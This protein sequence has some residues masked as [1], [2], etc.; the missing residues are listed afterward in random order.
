M[1]PS[2]VSDGT[3]LSR[4]EKSPS[5]KHASVA[6]SEISADDSLANSAT[7]SDTLHE[8]E[9]DHT[10]PKGWTSL[11]ELD[12]WK[13][14]V[15]NIPERCDLSGLS[16]EPVRY[17]LASTGLDGHAL[18][19]ATQSV[20]ILA[21]LET[22]LQDAATTQSL[23][24]DSLILFAV[25]QMLKGFGNGSHT[26]TATLVPQTK[27]APA[28]ASSWRTSA[29]IVD[30]NDR[31]S[32]SV[33]KAMAEIASIQTSPK[34]EDED[35][36]PIILHDLVR[37][38]LVD[39]FVVLGGSLDENILPAFPLVLHIGQDQTP[40]TLTICYTADLFDTMVIQSFLSA[41]CTLLWATSQPDKLVS[42]IEL[43]PTE[44]VDQM[45]QWNDTDGDWPTE[46]RL[47]HLFEESTQR[48]P[49]QIAII[50]GDKRVTYQELNELANLL[51]RHICSMGIKPEQLIGLFLDK[52]EKMI[53]AIL[54]VWKSGAAHVPID[55][56]YPNER[57]QFVLDDTKVQVLFASERHVQRLQEDVTGDREIQIIALEP[58]L[59]TL[60]SARS[61]T[62][63][64][65]QNLT[66]LPL[67][68][69]QLAYVTY[70]SGTTG[71]P[72]GIFKEHTSVVNSITD[73]SSKYGVADGEDEVILLFSAYV[74]EPFV[75]QM[76]MALT[77]GH[78][79]AIIRDEDKFDP[80]TLLPFIQTHKVT[81]LNG[82]ASVLQE[83]DFTTCPSLRRIILVGE[84]LTEARYMALRR[85]F[86]ARLFNEYGFTESAFVTALNIFEPNSSRKDMS[87]GRPVRN[88]K[89]YILD[90]NL[91][92]V[93]LGV[94]GELHIGGLGISR[95]Y[96]NRAELTRQKFLA[97][98]FQTDR[99]RERGLN[100][101]MYKTGDLAR[102]LPNGQVEYLGRADFQIKLRGIRIEPGEI[103]ATLA[104]YPGV[105]TSIVVSK[106]LLSQGQETN[107]DHLVAYFVCDEE[108][109]SEL[110]LLAFLETKLP[111]YMIPTRL[112]Q[113]TQIPV[114]INGKADL[115]ALP[116]VEVAVPRTSSKPTASQE[117]R[118]D[119]DENLATI[120]S[121]VLNVPREQIGLEQNFFRLG[122]HSITCI[123]LIARVRHVLGRGIN[124]EEV[125][126]TKT[127]RAMGDF[128]RSKEAVLSD[129]TS[130]DALCHASSAQ[131]DQTY[132][133]NS[134]QQG[135]VYHSLKTQQSDAYI[136][137][138]YLSY[139]VSLNAQLYKA[140]WEAV[141]KRH[142]ALRLR[143]SWEDQVSQ[144]VDSDA[145]LDWRVLDWTSVQDEAEQRRLLE[146]TQRADRTDAYSLDKGPLFRLYF[147]DLPGSRHW[148]IFSCHHSILDGWSLPLL[149][150]Y[151]HEAYLALVAGTPLTEDED[152]VYLQ[153]QKY[154]QEHRDDHLA[155][156]EEQIGRIDER[157]DMNALLNE[158]S[159][160]K[161]PLADYDQIQ[162][163]KTQTISLPWDDSV[164][165]LREECSA[166]GI[167]LHSILQL[168]WHLV[169]RAYGN[170][171]HT[172]T[173]TTIS[174]RNLPVGGVE[175]ALGLFIN[176]LPLIIDHDLCKDK[177]VL[178]AIA[179]VQNQVN[180]MNSRGHVELG[181]VSKDDLKHGLFDTL[182]VLENYPNLDTSKRALHQES[183]R[184]KIEGGTEKLS[185]PLAVIA[186][187]EGDSAC[188]FTIC[189][190]SE[191]FTD[192][193]IQDL[194]ETV[195]DA[196]HKVSQ[197]LDHPVREVEYLSSGQVMQ[198]DRWN[199][200]EAEFPNGTLHALFES[201][202][203]QKPDKIAVVYEDTSLTYRE[204]N[205][206]ANAMAYHLLSKV[207]IKPNQLIAL[208]IEKSEHLI[209]SILAVWKTG[210]AYVPIDAG[211]PDDRIKYILEDTRA[212]AVI[213][214]EKYI[215]R[216]R[217]LTEKPIPLIKSHMA[218]ELPR[219]H[220]HPLS[221][222]SPSDLAYTMYTSG[223]TGRP[224]GVM[225]E[226]HGVVNLAASLAQIFGLRETDDEV[227]LSFSN[228]VFDHFVEQMTDALLNGQTLVI[229]NDEM[230]GD[231][232]RLYRYIEK[233]KVTYLSGTPSVIS[234][235]EF[236]RFHS[237]L[238]RVDCVGEAFSEPVFDKIRETWPGL[239]INGYGPTEV[240]ITTHKR[241][242]PY[243]ERRTDKSIG[244]QV[245]NST[246]YVL[247]DDMKRVPI[248]AVGELYLGGDGV[249]RG[250]HNRPDLTA[251]RFPVNPF[252]SVQ[253]KRESRNGRLY[254][255]GDLVRWIQTDNGGEIEY[256]GRNDFQV[257]I[258]GQRI[259][260]GEIEAILSSF[261][262]IT[263][264]VILAKDRASDGQKYLV[265]YYVSPAAPTPQA[266][267][268]FM[269]ARL[270]DYMVP[271]RLMCID[272]FPVTVSGK[273]DSRALPIPDETVDGDIV[274]PRTEVERI[275]A[276]MWAELLDMSVDAI[277]IYSDFFSL[278]GDS[279]KSTRLSFAATQK[280]GVAVSV[281]SLFRHPTIESLAH[282][283]TRGSANLEEIVPLNVSEI[284]EIPVS[285]AQERLLYIYE[286]EGSGDAYNIPMH[287]E[288]EKGICLSSFE[289]AVRAMIGRHE[290]LRSLLVRS[291]QTS[292]HYQNIL[293]VDA[294]Q[295]L[296]T[297]E[298]VDCDSREAL[299][300][301]MS[302]FSQYSF[303]LTSE[304]PFCV[305]AYQLNG[306]SLHVS[307]VFHH[308]M[309]DAWSWDVFQRDLE[310]LYHAILS[311]GT[312]SLP[313]LRV[314]YKE[315]AAEHRKTLAS[316]QKHKVLVD[317]WS[318]KLADMEPLF[319]PTDRA[320][321]AQF[322]YAGNDVQLA[323]D[324][325]MTQNLREVAKREGSS[326]YTIM[327]TA[328]AFLLKVYT[329]QQDISIGIPV[330]HRT[331]PEFES[332][333]GFFINLLPLRVSVS[334]GS[335]HSLVKAV[336]KELV[337][338]Q[339]HQDMPFQEITK[340]LHVDHDPSR[341]PLVQTVFNWE[342]ES[343]SKKDAADRKPI[344]KEYSASGKAP[345][346]AKFDLNATIKE[347]AGQLM[348]NFN[349]ATSLF[350]E[351]TICGFLETYKYLLDQIVNNA[352]DSELS[353]HQATDSI[354]FETKKDSTAH[355]SQETLSAIFEHQV[356]LSANQI[357]ISDGS[358]RI[359]YSAL[360]EQANQLARWIMAT[361]EISSEDRIALMFDKSIEM[362]VSI[363]A[364]WK[365]GAAYVPLDPTYPPQRVNFILEDSNAKMIL[366]WKKHL[367]GFNHPSSTQVVALDTPE[368]ME[369]MQ[370]QSFENLDL[371]LSPSS[372]A[373]VI[374]TSGTTGKPKG[375][376]VEHRSVANLRNALVERYFGSTSGTHAVLLVSN[377]VF[378]FSLEQF[379]LSILSGNKLV[380]PPE[381]G[382][383]HECFYQIASQEK[384]TYISG[385]PSVLQQID[386]TRLAD[387]RMLTAAGEE[388]HRS[389]YTSMREQFKGPINNAYGITETT[390]YNL[391]TTFEGNA[392]FSKSLCE[393][394]PGSQ[395][396]VL[397]DQ[398]QRVPIN[399]VGELYL[400]GD[401][402][403]RGYLHQEAL[404]KDRF[405]PNP[406]S[407][408]EKMYKT[409]DLVRLRGPNQL[410][411]LGRRDQQVKL[412]GFRIE[413]AEVRDA[414]ASVPGVKESAVI[415]RY[416]GSSSSRTVSAL[417]GYYTLDDGV[418][419]TPVDIRERLG[420]FLPWFMIPSQFH[421][422][423]G[424]LPTTVNGKLDVARLAAIK[425]QQ[426]SESYSSPRNLLEVKLCQLWSSLLGLDACGIDDDLFALGGD[427]ISSLQLV[428]DIYRQL[429]RKV[430]VKDLF[431]HRTVRTLHDIV[432][433][434]DQKH[435]LLPPLRAEQGVVK[436]SAPLLP[437]QNWFLSK[438]LQQRDFW[439][440]CFSI[441]TPRLDVNQLKEAIEQL[442]D[443]H[444]IFRM[445]LRK[446]DGKFVQAFVENAT[447]SQLTELDVSKFADF[448]S[449]EKTLSSMQS[450]FNLE[451]G[452]LMAVSYLSGFKDGSARIW[453]A[454][455]HM[456]VD[457]VSWNI[458]L[459]DLETLY[460]GGNLGFKSSSIQQWASAVSNYTM[461][462]AE[463]TYWDE[464]RSK[465]AESTQALPR[466][467]T[468][469]MEYVK[470]KLS[471]DHTAA[472]FEQCCTRLG[473]SMLDILLVAVSTSLQAIMG[474][475]PTIV[476][477]EGHGREESVDPALEVSRT[478]GW[479][480]SM[481]PFEIPHVSDLIQAVLDVKESMRRIP[482][483]GIGYGPVYSYERES[484][485]AVSVNYLGRLD[486][487][488]PRTN[489]W[490]LAIGDSDFQ[491]GLVTS[492]EDAGKS[493][494]MIDITFAST[495]GQMVTQ[496]S[497]CLGA[498][499]TSTLL[500]SITKTLTEMVEVTSQTDFRTPAAQETEPEFTPFFA[501]QD[502]SRRGSPLFLLPPGEGGA[503]S[504]FHNIVQ[505]LSGRN[506]IAFN[507]HYRHSKSL[508]TIEELAEYYLSHIR[509]IQPEGPYHI[510]GWSFGGILALEIAQRLATTGQ[511]IGTM[512]LIDP[513]F[514]IPAAAQ[515]IGQS[516]VEI[517]DPIY[518]IYNPDP[519][520]FA[521]VAGQTSRMVL[522][523]ATSTNG[524]HGN[525]LQR[526]LYEWY[527][528]E[529]PLN[530][531]DVYVPQERIE[532]VPLNGTHFTWVHDAEQVKSMCQLLDEC[533]E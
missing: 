406:F 13:S 236:S 291:R 72:K 84:N 247:N 20:V 97:N 143:F 454:M 401:C 307:F 88:V 41:L 311:K 30:H 33:G 396:H 246:S 189:Y 328:Y 56:A 456:I 441:R 204:L 203:Q 488:Q 512:A 368:V 114:T 14:T 285:P 218:L 468:H 1:A 376:L 294:A 350:D 319:L 506:M 55:P 127:L 116:A 292:R 222:A 210:G 391:I 128:L 498:E 80:N 533:L 73:L 65:C 115:R 447:S 405:L 163:Q 202:A 485:P 99:E 276:H 3:A 274:H 283:I 185:Y 494:S 32:Q 18:V 458:I 28:T 290:A 92:R 154:L 515:D 481:Y 339:I 449:V 47:H 275:L 183:L 421:C 324:E 325:H 201:E 85:R 122:G 255:T 284:S 286:F 87:L 24:V 23:P 272:K 521:S 366:T 208:V 268:C 103:E 267:R 483:N 520:A 52:S 316:A 317:F 168:V 413:L 524:Q 394:L 432:L 39:L 224:K 48:C 500:E 514:D 69:K 337:D 431:L 231:K 529:S 355:K 507:N 11:T 93:P 358:R 155:F 102:W 2:F 470:G 389:Q 437:I 509:Q 105:R 9:N 461:S 134:L 269:R 253:E 360:N 62:G 176:T 419:C 150:E 37:A 532:V 249:A 393:E 95:G 45:N 351:Q 68:S 354:T 205:S 433:A 178:E 94:T 371:A 480:T 375:V 170:G 519:A 414:L 86:K 374:F 179:H 180:A 101:L 131:L 382:L 440:H 49:D 58:L 265:G 124:V 239:I 304:L 188:R 38:E 173:G 144:V 336:Q 464:I 8:D 262:E 260:L 497:S 261:P 412:R 361:S 182:F 67:T 344:L 53:A 280:L 352:S 527:A 91:K 314:Q 347:S 489:D 242:Y 19:T 42:E 96:M 133:A 298:S 232:E 130:E 469:S 367:G 420:A 434:K 258:R 7:T 465:V 495:E 340:L 152:T 416:D 487:V 332:V 453:F 54:G 241:L 511:S 439:N 57:V 293:D 90:T 309:F 256:L 4:H 303:S 424:S 400:S 313:A 108:T 213:A 193:T 186:Q 40:R 308:A 227:I 138:N 118:D 395:V 422:L 243:P 89:C 259:E 44:Q 135:F 305:R 499:T 167:T 200:T 410:E 271:S 299:E 330:A 326:L 129:V 335:I 288:L 50:Y 257:K 263:Q 460:K 399:A 278:G 363:L 353:M 191:L 459:S 59:D 234:M 493:S 349:Y 289:G 503:E 264:S 110:D 151:V 348:V 411:Y 425:D 162:Q 35:E 83:Y 16:K 473:A 457:T 338:A 250:Y 297:M 387:L 423:Q 145:S 229:L 445:R 34:A 148:C 300:A 301:S 212:L 446:E 504:Y 380:I 113:L 356:S 181:R 270:P 516:G 147:I 513:Y 221:A 161:V 233:N 77:T 63:D 153:C 462:S 112:V 277:S 198:L 12:R 219:S 149:F 296:F 333:I 472:L 385:T 312:A 522:F 362:M 214:D 479:F 244:T 417:V 341:H 223:T 407:A 158:A 171:S 346:V 206:R 190:A 345:S 390:V 137:Q 403:A 329:N 466:V 119:I 230:R 225:V 177:T 107:Q 192:E 357:A 46:K 245:A 140:A 320:R 136:M 474:D 120:W 415:P 31:G 491:H 443:R 517:L 418:V 75:R 78:K 452:P 315:Y 43:L 372:L 217:G 383:T 64:Q 104:M 448:A 79:L 492:P 235:Y 435:A 248:G 71:F 82:T 76:L 428:G 169:L 98:P 525:P 526:K 281:S 379:C 496:I 266:I 282:W 369:S 17:Q 302:E 365:A 451:N 442:Q 490:T 10:G 476:T 60:L 381:E 29:T 398:L 531:L 254:K 295:K 126:Q 209:T 211:Y 215:D 216:L 505:G 187:E 159:R 226:H 228:Y 142:P 21:E 508:A 207:T 471:T 139:E 392:P 477:M 501:F 386:L 15:Q 463:R 467:V 6:V 238:R 117:F 530:N 359:S 106:K 334:Q 444:D 318:S 174:G 429:N 121:D 252:Q 364:V 402:V 510:L 322:D 523:K 455:H 475:A 27:T 26:T 279:L 5:Q 343:S 141:H 123:Q 195:R 160:Y 404:T 377:Y 172:I 273:L 430:T 156:W 426:Q 36:Q 66:H 482:N 25:H 370:Q 409:G 125:F 384:L 81:Y 237:H 528:E 373:Y 306:E 175:R 74:F 100:S 484:M 408:G 164:S 166:R 111:R 502:E 450:K 165:A 199:A 70:T 157:C 518:H 331:H 327:L 438:P 321:L 287:F 486:Q 427:S 323:I 478:V 310:S 240:S 194:L 436:G 342:G 251:E 22:R 146:Q 196:F 220:V 109:L 197:N 378:D 61:T 397:N 388:F 51:A 132:V 184:Y